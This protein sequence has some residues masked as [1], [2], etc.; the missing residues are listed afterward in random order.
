MKRLRWVT[1]LAL[2]GLLAAACGD[3]EAE[4]TTTTTAAATT[5]ATEATTTTAGPAFDGLSVVAPDCDYGGNLKSIEAVDQYTVKFT[6]CATDVAFAS[7]A[8]FT[9]LAILPQELLESSGGAPLDVAVGTGPYKLEAWDKGNQMV[10]TRNDGYWGD[11]AIAQTLVFRWS[12]EAAQRLV[13][14]QSGQVDG[15]DNVGTED[16]DAVRNDSNLQLLERPGLN[17]FYLGLNRDIPPFD[18]EGVRQAIAMAIDKQRIVDNF[19]PK[20]SSIAEQFLPP[21]IFGYVDTV[22]W[23]DYDVEAAKQ[24]LADAGFPDGFEV[25]LSYRDVVR[26]YLP[27]PGGV[28]TDLQAQLAEIG[29]TVNIEVMES[30]AFL[31][32]AD[33]GQLPMYLL[34]WGAD[35]PDATNFYD[36]HFGGGASPQFGA[37]FDDL[38]KVLA[39]AGSVA[40]PAARLDLYTTAAELVKQYVPMVPVAHGGSGVAYR[41]DVTGGQASPLGNEYMAVM[42]PG[43]RDTLVWMQNAE[44]ISLY[45]ADESDGESLRACEQIYEALLS[46]EIGG[47]AVEPAL[48][49]E[50]TPN[51]DGTEWTFTLRQGVTFHDGSTFDANDVVASYAAQWDAAN[52]LHVGRNGDFVYF[53]AFFGSFLNAPAS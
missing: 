15:I 18:N 28:A 50:Y 26:G 39:D 14:L 48:A 7:K 10:F 22:P 47:T 2:V 20:G 6:L 25:T 37:K 9:S 51:E 23:Y 40:D 8:A 27:N 41:A 43:G 46:Y 33:A 5:E 17:I 24:M 12:A 52:P 36:F 53:T 16:F 45:C 4:E 44:P 29:I 38:V 32:A 13:E 31:D 35:Y 21:D 30:G 1:I 19:Y 49:T 34:G 3:G 42:D 11:P